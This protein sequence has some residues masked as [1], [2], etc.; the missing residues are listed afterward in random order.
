M[1]T[2][3]AFKDPRIVM[4]EENMLRWYERG[5][6]TEADI[7]IKDALHQRWMILRDL[8]QYDD[9]AKQLLSDFNERINAAAK[10]LYKKTEAVYKGISDFYSTTDHDLEVE[11]N[12]LLGYDYPKN[13][14]VQTKRAESMWELLTQGGYDSVY[15]MNGCS[16]KLAWQENEIGIMSQSLDDWLGMT[17]HNDNWN[18]GLDREWSKDLHLGYP[19][20]HLYAN[21]HFSLYDLVYVNEFE[22]EIS[23]RLDGRLVN[24]KK[25]HIEKDNNWENDIFATLN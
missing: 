10:K 24:N 6:A 25:M 12:L 5:K 2:K 11:G 9:E 7:I 18:E 19:F 21:C 8:M 13:H 15:S 17:D 4:L 14:P 16:W 20:H 22:Y 23:V 1:N 3:E